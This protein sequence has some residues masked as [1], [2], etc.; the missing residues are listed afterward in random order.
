MSTTD[1]GRGDEDVERVSPEEGEEDVPMGSAEEVG[2]WSEEPGG[3]SD[4][5]VGGS[6]GDLAGG[7][8]TESGGHTESGAEAGSGSSERPD[9]GGAG[10]DVGGGMTSGAAAGAADIDSE[11]A[12]ADLR[13]GTGRE[14]SEERL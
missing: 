12:D 9:A 5:V 10:T 1:R 7:G 4:A 2:G 3:A 14:E 6:L 11:R 8:W 13:G